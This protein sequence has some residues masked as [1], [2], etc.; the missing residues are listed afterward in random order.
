MEVQPAETSILDIS[1]VFAGIK[2]GGRLVV[3]NL[4]LGSMTQIVFIKLIW[5]LVR[6]IAVSLAKRTENEIDDNL[7]KALDD[8]F[9]SL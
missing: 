3:H 6:P 2:K 4:I 5:Q 8:F 1:I 9:K 7:V